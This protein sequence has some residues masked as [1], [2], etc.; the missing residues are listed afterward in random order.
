MPSDLQNSFL[1]LV[2]GS[3]GFSALGK[4]LERQ[5]ELKE[6]L[7]PRTVLGFVSSVQSLGYKGTIPGIGDSY[8]SLNKS[9]G[10]INDITYEK[11]SNYTIAA[12]LAIL[13]GVS[14]DTRLAKN[15]S[16][17]DLERLGKVIDTLV[18]SR[19]LRQGMAKAD[20]PG[21]TAKPIKQKG[22]TAPSFAPKAPATN[23]KVSSKKLK[24]VAAPPETDES[25]PGLKPLKP[26]TG[27]KP[28]E[29]K[30]L[31]LKVGK[32]EAYNPCSVCGT[33]QFSKNDNGL[34]GCFCYS[35]LIKHTTI[36]NRDDHYLVKF[37]GEWSVEAVESFWDAIY[38]GQS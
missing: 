20:Q 2:L 12:H 18:K 16:G 23:A 26:P 30:P 15:T 1:E 5:P 19:M 27:D 4:A 21:A 8:I 36:V 11:C 24:P 14:S 29:L 37:G 9:E 34:Y 7:I 32:S 22:P 33:A 35:E 25:I 3:D 6:V 31:T 28:K 10:V 13:L 17:I 38:G